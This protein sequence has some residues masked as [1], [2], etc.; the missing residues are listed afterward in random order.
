[1]RKDQLL[2]ALKVQEALQVYQEHQVLLVL[3][4]PKELR[5]L[6]DQQVHLVYKDHQVLRVRQ[7][8]KVSKVHKVQPAL[9]VSREQLGQ[10]DLNQLQ[11]QPVQQAYQA[12]LGRKVALAQQGFKGDKVHKA[13][14][15][16][17]AAP[18]LLVPKGL[19]ELKDQAVLWV[20]V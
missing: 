10:Q 15:V 8:V 2:A 1:M 14:Q 13:A 12:H 3:K 7:D 4:E 5:V 11:G 19:R 9:K 6:R 18:V 16:Q 20:P 17:L